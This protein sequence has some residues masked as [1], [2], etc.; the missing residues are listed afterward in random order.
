MRE[1]APVNNETLRKPN[2]TLVSE[3]EELKE[4]GSVEF[5]QISTEI[6]KKYEERMAETGS[7]EKSPKKLLI[8]E[9]TDMD[10]LMGRLMVLSD[11]RLGANNVDMVDAV[12]D[13]K[14]LSLDNVGGIIV[15]GSASD[16]VEKE[17][18]P[19][20]GEMEE[21][22]K[23]ALDRKIP[24]M[25]ICF[26]IQVHADLKGREVPK[27]EGGREM[28][29]WDTAVYLEG[30]EVKHPIFNGLDFQQDDR[31]RKSALL[32]TVGSHAYHAGYNPPTEERN[33]HGIHF[34]ESG[35]GYPMIE[36]DGSFV[37]TQFH[38][39]LSIPEGLAILKAL[40]KKRADK[41]VADDKDPKAILKE[42]EQYEI[43]IKDGKND[44]RTFLNNFVSM[45]FEKGDK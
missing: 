41:L 6:K 39:E 17:Q 1:R 31:G 33:I 40:V 24:V 9:C 16:I 44:N 2:E 32:K 11:G 7:L 23:E 34:T 4:S 22:V 10:Y 25:G 37:G 29:I 30:D 12:N 27:N 18:K 21:F 45:V 36:I 42:I 13:G 5:Q 19:W 35:H 28:G 3:I 20:I 38:P 15:S 8:L 43:D 14:D 26:G